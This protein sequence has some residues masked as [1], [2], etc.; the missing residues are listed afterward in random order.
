MVEHVIHNDE[1][2]HENVAQHKEIAQNIMKI[3]EKTPH[4]QH[5]VNLM[6]IILVGSG[7]A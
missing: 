6:V 2:I 3:S 7:I 5:E 4:T 1:K